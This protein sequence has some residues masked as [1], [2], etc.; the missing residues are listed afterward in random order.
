MANHTDDNT[1]DHD[2][3]SNCPATNCIMA[4]AQLPLFISLKFASPWI[5]ILVRVTEIEV[6]ISIARV[7]GNALRNNITFAVTSNITRYMLE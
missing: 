5:I 6:A 4:L 3:S 2:F 1:I 7:G